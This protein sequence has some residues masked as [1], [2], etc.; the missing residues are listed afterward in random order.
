MDMRTLPHTRSE[1]SCGL[2]SLQRLWFL[3][4]I[5]QG[6]CGD[7]VHGSDG[8]AATGRLAGGQS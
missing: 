8:G 3:S 4:Q 2:E 7:A 1:A 6:R 5:H